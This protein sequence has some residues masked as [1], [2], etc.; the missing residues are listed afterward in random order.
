MV[1]DT[2]VATGSQ[3]KLETALRLAAEKFEAVATK[4][5]RGGDS[6]KIDRVFLNCPMYWGAIAHLWFEAVA[7]KQARFSL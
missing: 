3:Q 5:V 7:T 1:Q 2:I 4:Q 6:L